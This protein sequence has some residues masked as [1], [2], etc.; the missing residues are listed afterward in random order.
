MIIKLETKEEDAASHLLSQLL[1]EAIE[2]HDP[3][4]IRRLRR[5]WR[6]DINGR[7][8]KHGERWA[9]IKHKASVEGSTWYVWWMEGVRNFMKRKNKW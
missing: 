1:E 9:S 3:N 5:L 8:S 7:S 6:H 4:L 2:T